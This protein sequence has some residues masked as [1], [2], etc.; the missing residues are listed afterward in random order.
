MEVELTRNVKHV[1]SR[2]QL[3]SVNKLNAKYSMYERVFT[4]H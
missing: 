1:E 3:I 2:K 4:F